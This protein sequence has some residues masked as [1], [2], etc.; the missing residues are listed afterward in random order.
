M[1]EFANQ[2][3]HIAEKVTAAQGAGIRKI[4]LHLY[5][6]WH[7]RTESKSVSYRHFKPRKQQ[8]LEI[9]GICLKEN[10]GDTLF[11]WHFRKNK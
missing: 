5:I 9:L 1:L 6:L 7:C 4:I 10:L 11:T 2:L 8:T 3:G